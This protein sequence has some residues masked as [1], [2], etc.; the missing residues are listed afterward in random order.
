MHYMTEQTLNWEYKFVKTLKTN[1]DIDSAVF[2]NN[3]YCKYTAHK[4]YSR[5]KYYKSSLRKFL[6]DHNL[7]RPKDKK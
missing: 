1:N 6:I 4:L 7:Y 3:R 5:I 2:K